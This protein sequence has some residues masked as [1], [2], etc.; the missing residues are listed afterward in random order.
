[1]KLT[2]RKIALCGVT[3][4]LYAAIT[5]L[6]SSFAYGQVQFRIAEALTVLCCF[7][8]SMVIGATLG[9]FVANIFSTVSAL[10]MVVGTLGTLIACLCMVR[11]KK[12]WLAAIPNVVVNGVMIGALIAWVTAPGA[13]FWKV[14][15]ISGL[16]VA[17][18][19]LVVMV[20]LGVPLF[21]YLKKSGLIEK[22]VGK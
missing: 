2:T 12:A 17:V 7:E 14:F 18:G 22:L 6:T 9:C 3:A 16:Q 4:G 19:E 10:D 1:M 21:V 11:C 15:F 13:G 8:P 20:V 5:L